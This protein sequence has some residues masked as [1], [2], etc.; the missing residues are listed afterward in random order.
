MNTP[1]VPETKASGLVVLLAQHRLDGGLLDAQQPPARSAS[2]AH[3]NA[4]HIETHCTNK[5]LNQ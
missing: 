4:V 2:F 1:C 3:R 5:F